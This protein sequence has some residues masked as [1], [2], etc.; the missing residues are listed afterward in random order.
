MSDVL[1]Y[2]T[3]C[4]E[5]KTL[6]PHLWKVGQA[7]KTYEGWKPGNRSWRNNNPGNLRSSPL[8]DGNDEGFATFR[9][10]YLGFYALLLDLFSKCTGRTKTS[11]LPTSTLMDLMRVYAPFEDNN[12]P[13]SYA[14]YVASYAGLSV[15]VELW[16][17][18]EEEH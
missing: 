3:Y 5:I 1:R 10:Y 14:V 13:D 15:D 7:I 11:L 12:K 9:D 6:H 17:L 8:A 16:R 2:R 4:A 18:L